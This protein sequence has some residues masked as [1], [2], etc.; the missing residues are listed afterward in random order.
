MVSKHV[1]HDLKLAQLPG[2]KIEQVVVTSI[3]NVTEQCQMF[4]PYFDPK[5]IIHGE[6]LGCLQVQ[7]GHDLKNRGT[8]CVRRMAGLPDTVIVGVTWDL[9]HH[10]AR[11][12][13]ER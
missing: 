7:I 13:F 9:S 12:A 5:V 8:R 10:V 11:S 2:Q 3:P 4:S 6:K 1:E